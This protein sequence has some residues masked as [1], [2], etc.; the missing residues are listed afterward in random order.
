[1]MRTTTR[2]M[3]AG[4]TAAVLTTLVGACASGPESEQKEGRLS[5]TQTFFSEHML[6]SGGKAATP[7]PAPGAVQ[8]TQEE[9][10]SGWALMEEAWTAQ[11]P[12][13]R[14]VEPYRVDPTPPDR[15]ARLA[16]R[17][18]VSQLDPFADF[19]TPSSRAGFG[20]RGSSIDPATLLYSDV[21]GNDMPTETVDLDETAWAT[22]NVK[23]I[24]FSHQ[25]ADF[26]P[27]VSRTGDT[28][29]YASTQHRPTA[30]IYIKDVTSRVV[31]RLT[32]D[33]AQD[34]MPAVS[35]DG[36]HIAFC[37]NRNGTWDLFIMPATGGK[38]VQLTDEN[39][40]DLHPSWSPDGSKIV[41]CRL[42]QSSGRWELWIADVD[43]SG[44]SQFIG[45]GLFPEWCPQ[46]GT[47]YRGTDKI[48]FQ[49]SRERGDRAF[50]IWTLDYNANPARAGRET[51]IIS[52]PDSAMINPSWSPDG[53]F[54]LFA[55]VPERAAGGGVRPDATEVWMVGIDGRARVKLTSGN[56]DLMPVWGPS[57]SIFFVSDRAGVE[58]VW[59]IDVST[60]IE[61]A[62]A[63]IPE[64][65]GT[66]P[67]FA[68]V[69]TDE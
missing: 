1:M 67:S 27:I 6:T 8:P 68:N 3:A 63:Q 61:A 26:D 39:T 37:S 4:C 52:A 46:P 31:T 20:K 48:A 60:A 13:A 69:P 62:T 58:N 54:L 11:V 17:G 53:R 22:S 14:T 42:G 18:D 15:V 29:V 66:V 59:A 35:P 5:R 2:R 44:G 47:G 50:G 30:D 19:G 49:R 38:A 65:A 55:E 28:V 33:P 64:L 34:V 7:A 16:S 23:Q 32:D 57:G 51:E 12:V 24:T 25:G 36:Q 21:L 10:D 43:S 45:Y 56:V 40:H 9:T 41:F